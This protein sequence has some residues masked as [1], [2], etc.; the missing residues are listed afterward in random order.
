[1]NPEMLR[2]MGVRDAP[3]IPFAEGVVPYG[4]REWMRR[5]VAAGNTPVGA[6]RGCVVD[7]V[8][9][10]KLSPSQARAMNLTAG[11]AARKG[12]LCK[13]VGGSAEHPTVIALTPEEMKSAIWT[14]SRNGRS[15]VRTT[16]SD[17]ASLASRIRP[18]DI[19]R[20]SATGETAISAPQTDRGPG[21]TPWIAG[22]LILAMA[23]GLKA[24]E[25]K[26][27]AKA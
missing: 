4:S 13:V 17:E 9:F 11:E 23:V 1:M 3:K 19:R 21:A 14:V 5:H 18:G 27:G 2:A 24:A 8:R 6:Y 22:G 10:P 26:M 15:G 12:M 20:M 25:V 16:G 7:Y